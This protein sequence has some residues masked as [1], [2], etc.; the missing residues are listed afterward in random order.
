MK[1][2]SSWKAW[3]RCAGG[4]GEI[5]GSGEGA[6]LIGTALFAFLD[7]RSDV[8]PRAT[9]PRGKGP[10]NQSTFPSVLARG[11]GGA[12]GPVLF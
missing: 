7:R 1:S 12:G 8:G 5:H 10:Q 9:G 3:I 11:G 2:M 6:V 4:W